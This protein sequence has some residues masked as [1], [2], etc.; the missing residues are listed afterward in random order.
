[1]PLTIGANSGRWLRPA[2]LAR[3]EPLL[4][5]LST[6][7]PD[8][9]SSL[10]QSHTRSLAAVVSFDRGGDHAAVLSRADHDASRADTDRRTR[11]AMIA[12]AL[13]TDIPVATHFDLDLGHFEIFRFGRGNPAEWRSGRE[14]D[15]GGRHGK[16]DSHHLMYLC[17]G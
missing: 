15:R 7:A 8:L 12:T 13:F 11:L 16:R 4:K 14:N 5:Q 3:G 10:V 1:V 2:E 9:N 17:L 6:L